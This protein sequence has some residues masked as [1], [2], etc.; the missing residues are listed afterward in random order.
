MPLVIVE[1][2]KMKYSLSKK[3][4]SPVKRSVTPTVPHSVRLIYTLRKSPRKRIVVMSE[5]T[6]RAFVA[7]IRSRPKP[8]KAMAKTKELTVISPDGSLLIHAFDDI[9]KTRTI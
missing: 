6:K 8:K 1:R 4:V 3:M 9:L 7:K 5:A 2:H